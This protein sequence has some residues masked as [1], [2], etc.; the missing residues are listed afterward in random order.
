MII[1]SRS[2]QNFLLMHGD[3]FVKN[4][5]MKKLLFLI[6]CSLILSASKCKKEGDNCHYNI[7]I[8][9]N[10]DNNVVWGIVSNGI[11]GCRISGEEL[12]KSATAKFSPSNWCI[13]S[14][15]SNDKAIN[16]YIINPS[17]FN[18][19]DV[20]YSCD[21]VAHKNTILKHYVLTLEDLKQIDFTIIYP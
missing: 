4:R 9:N 3:L 10:S 6:M 2:V 17:H 1:L 12:E 21:S 19:P 15:L 18:A 7:L 5:I 20:F 14:R 16:I 11:Y 8:K 13:E